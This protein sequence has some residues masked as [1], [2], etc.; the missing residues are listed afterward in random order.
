MTDSTPPTPAGWFPDPAGSPRQRYWDGAQWTEHFHPPALPAASAPPA[1]ASIIAGPAAPAVAVPPHAAPPHAASIIA[2]APPRK[3]RRKL[4]LGLVAGGVALALIATTAVVVV[5]VPALTGGANGRVHDDPDWD[6]SYT[7][8]MI[9]I[10]PDHEFEFPVDYDLDAMAE[11]YAAENDPDFAETGFTSKSFAFEV[12]LDAAFTKRAGAIVGQLASGDVYVTPNNPDYGRD[13]DFVEYPIADE[14]GAWGL[15]DEYFLM[16]RLD[17]DGTVLE[18]PVVTRFTAEKDLDTPR[19]SFSIPENSGDVDFSWEPVTGA[20]EYVVVTSNSFESTGSRDFTVLAVTDQTTWSSA[21]AAST[22]KNGNPWVTEQNAEMQMF[23][24]G[25]VDDIAS[26]DRS[27]AGYKAEYD[28]GVIATDGERYSPY[29]THDALEVAGT[30]PYVVAEGESA[31]LKRWGPSG[32]V[33]GIE[34]VQ[35]TVPF[36]SL[37]GVTRSTVASIDPAEVEERDDRWILPLKARGTKLGEWVA[38]LKS[39]V[40]DLGA[41]IADYNVRAAAGAPA[42]GMPAFT[43]IS[44]PIDEFAKGVKDAPETDY[45]VFGSTPFTKFLA[46]HMIA[47]TAVIDISD[48]AG[49]PGVPDVYD[50]VYE[51]EY[52]NPYV[53]NMRSIGVSADGSKLTVTYD[54]SAAEAAAL[55][56]AIHDQVEQ[57]VGSVVTEGM[58]DREKVTV[59]NDWIAQ[60]ADYDDAALASIATGTYLGVPP[61]YENSWNAAGVLLDK[62][63]VCASYA[64]AFNALANAAGVETVVVTGEVVSGGSHAWNKVR[65]D[66]AWLAV[67]PT[68]NDSPDA[69]RFLLINDSAFTDTATRTEN[70]HWM[71]DLA[72][73]DY[74]TP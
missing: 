1:A 43:T 66:G 65:I 57:V 9:G 41:A 51:A 12:Y 69:N 13:G 4:V 58:S 27:S 40:P 47:Q 63:G 59:L 61:G 22:S 25:S 28:F 71:T 62:T 72:I 37:D 35:L 45:P 19:V 70:A 5:V 31:T 24:G 73:P 21:N 14:F 42:T 26:G 34:N 54:H 39:S 52:Q 7:D 50:A 18:K 46:T 23:D 55:Q 36:T 20:T 49:K 2:G 67:D 11:E 6:Y 16:R 44:A 53:V 30:L 33:E 64:Y 48:F 32:T 38:L 56:K 17:S 10:A 29:E 60:N 8:P 74:A 68:W 15:H 3:K